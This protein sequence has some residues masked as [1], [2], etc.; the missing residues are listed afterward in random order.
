MAAMI[1]SARVLG[2]VKRLGARLCGIPE[3]VGMKLQ[4][5]LLMYGI[6]DPELPR[7]IE[8]VAD[9]DDE[10]EVQD[11]NEDADNDEDDDDGD[12][13]DDSDDDKIEQGDESP[14]PPPSPPDPGLSSPPA[15][16]TRKS[17]AYAMRGKRQ[18]SQHHGQLKCRHLPPPKSNPGLQAISSKRRRRREVAQDSGVGRESKWV[19]GPNSSAHQVSA[20]FR[21][22]EW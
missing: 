6:A 21:T 18:R 4:H 13:Q 8:E 10:D 20:W 2:G 1:R 5:L 3:D 11:D 12:Y 19:Y 15:R 16:R 7:A 17:A 22:A 9:D 14:C